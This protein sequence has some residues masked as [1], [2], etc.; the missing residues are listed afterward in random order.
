[1]RRAESIAKT[2]RSRGCGNDRA[3]SRMNPTVRLA[4]A[5]LQ[6]LWVSNAQ[7]QNSGSSA[8]T[9][10]PPVLSPVGRPFEQPLSP[11]SAIAGTDTSDA[12]VTRL[13]SLFK[14]YEPGSQDYR[15]WGGLSLIAAGAI[16]IPVVTVARS[17]AGVRSSPVEV[18]A[19]GLGG[20]ELAGGL[21]VLLSNSSPFSQLSESLAKM[22]AARRPPPEILASIEWDWKRAA[23]N[24]RSTRQIAGIAATSIGALAIGG[25]TF[26]ALRDVN[27]LSS[28]D[29][30]GF[31]AASLTAGGLSLLLGLR[32]IFFEDPIEIAW[33]S[34]QK[35]DLRW[36]SSMAPAR[37]GVPFAPVNIVCEPAP[38]GAILGFRAS[39]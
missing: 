7:A 17:H 36:M 11:S 2:P 6:V 19:A 34:W 9:G 21:V 24:A 37:L 38:G 4:L 26:L 32:E 15:L 25:G 12:Q 16:T 28:E 10:T 33:R 13:E 18:L 14:H 1:M 30:F 5:V 8:A 31:S 39:M 22:R 35:G 3:M 20:G 29:R 23:D 27:G